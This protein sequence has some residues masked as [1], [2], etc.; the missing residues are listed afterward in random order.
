MDGYLCRSLDQRGASW[1]QAV[2]DD[3]RL[4]AAQRAAVLRC[5]PAEW[6][7][8]E[9]V[10]RNQDDDSAY[11][12]TAEMRV[13][14]PDHMQ[15][16]I[17]RLVACGRAWDAIDSVSLSIRSAK[18]EGV[19]T[20]LTADVL[21]GLLHVACTQKS[22]KISSLS[23]EVGQVLDHIVELKADQVDVARLELLLYPL[24]GDYRESIVLHRTLATE[25][26]LF[27]G[28]MEVAH[29]DKTMLGMD[30]S[31][32][33]RRAMS[34]LDGWRGCPGMTADGEL[35]AV[36]MQQW[37][38]AARQGLA[39]AELSDIGDYEIGRLLANSPED[40]N[41]T[42]PL[43]AV[44]TLIDEVGSKNLDEG[45]IAGTCRGLMSSV[46]GIY[47]GGQQEHESAQRY[48]ALSRQIR[49]TSRHTA[50][51]LKKAADRYEERAVEEDD[52]AEARQDAL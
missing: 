26:H 15:Y 12:Q 41:G 51:L 22:V 8:W 43:P 23:Y 37:V 17:E 45:F 19:K 42:W 49:S 28:L 47:D 38:D 34:V 32:S 2:L 1:L 24:I 35:D 44:C 33:F 18:Q 29:R 10:A 40:E 27:V 3:S 13:L 48:H 31:A 14:P 20:D 21:I 30:R 52:Q 11:W 7:Y 5:A 46:R 50:R 36:V 6:D 4:T 25:P 16:A 9:V 39:A